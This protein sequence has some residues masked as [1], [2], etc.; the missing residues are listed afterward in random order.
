MSKKLILIRSR[1]TDPGAFSIEDDKET[2][3]RL[4]REVMSLSGKRVKKATTLA[5]LSDAIVDFREA[6]DE[7]MRLNGVSRGEMNWRQVN[8]RHLK[9]SYESG[10]AALVECNCK[11]DKPATEAEHKCSVDG[12]DKPAV[13]QLPSEQPSCCKRHDPGH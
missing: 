10:R 6:A 3:A 1:E 8:K 5:E 4:L 9:G 2:H 7:L 12:C 13:D 11:Y